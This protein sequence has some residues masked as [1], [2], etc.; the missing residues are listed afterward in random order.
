MSPAAVAVSLLTPLA[1]EYEIRPAAGASPGIHCSKA[2]MII[3]TP[4]RLPAERHL[5]GSFRLIAGR[6]GDEE[7]EQDADYRGETDEPE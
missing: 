7:A 2:A 3:E 1:H 4:R 6:R 5:A